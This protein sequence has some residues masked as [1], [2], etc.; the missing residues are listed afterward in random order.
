MEKQ[1]LVKMKTI[2]LVAI[3]LFAGAAKAQDLPLPPLLNEIG[4]AGALDPSMSEGDSG[5]TFIEAIGYML[6]GSPLMVSARSQISAAQGRLQQSKYLQNPTLSLEL[7]NFGRKEDASPGEMTLG[8]EQPFELWGKR[9]NKKKMLQAELEAVGGQTEALM[10]ELYSQTS[11]AFVELLG[12]QQNLEYSQRR[13]ELAIKIE[14]A[15][16]TKHSSGAVS[17][18][19]LLR[20]Q[21]EKNLVQL[22]V[23]RTESNLVAAK[24]ALASLWGSMAVN[25][26][27][28]GSLEWWMTDF[29]Q[30]ALVT[31]VESNPEIKSLKANV[32]ARQAEI[33]LSKAFGKPDI[34]FGAGYRR[35]YDDNDNSFLVWSAIPLP[36]FDRNKGAILESRANLSMAEAELILARQRLSKDLKG[37]LAKLSVIRNSARTIRDRILPTA[38]QAVVEIDQAYQLGSQA[39]INVLDAQRTLAEI[40]SQLVETLVEGARIAI[41]IEVITGKPFGEL[42]R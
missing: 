39:Y 26:R 29:S 5:V 1:R 33:Q 25:G 7:E 16:G 31:L 35:L 27:A 6:G 15:V 10:L 9:G 40:E 34:S 28:V 22:D 32:T 36:L 17:K 20:A 12:I 4:I 24:I 14:E 13:L 30:D 2:M 18:A 21:S 3:T 42:R 19:E 41:E 8:I 23:N 38:E 11:Q 37:R